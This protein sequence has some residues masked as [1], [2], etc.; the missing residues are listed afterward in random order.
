M[1]ILQVRVNDELRSKASEISKSLGIDLTTAVRMFLQQM[2]NER[3][4]PF[5]P[6]L[7][8]FYSNVNQARLLQ[9]IESLNNGNTVTKTIAELK[10]LT[11]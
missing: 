10:E 2:I 9:S 3:G 5:K 7:D 1:S 11:K 4:L 6:K 8:P